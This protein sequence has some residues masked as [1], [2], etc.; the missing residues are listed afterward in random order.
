MDSGFPSQKRKTVCIVEDDVALCRALESMINDGEE[1]C[2]LGTY[3]WA[4]HALDGVP[5]RHPDLVVADIALP[6][7]RGTECVWRL[8]QKLP[9]L[10][11]L[12]MTGH[13][14]DELL[15]EAL[16]AGADGYIEKPCLKDEFLQALRTLRDGKTPLAERAR[17]ALLRHFREHGPKAFLLET[18]TDRERQVLAWLGEGL[19]YV[20]IAGK[21]GI[22]SS[23]VHSHI[24]NLY[25]KLRVR[26]RAAALGF[27]RRDSS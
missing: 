6:R 15:F 26:T 11:A 12:V 5:R 1:F 19:R 18:L 27:L 8:K 4:E 7:M 16:A 10:R 20:E 23:T 13:P 24:H 21:L 3:Q 9:A 22:A 14:S 2:C 17:Q 25:E